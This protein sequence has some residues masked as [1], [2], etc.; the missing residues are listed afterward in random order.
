MVSPADPEPT[1]SLASPNNI[2]TVSFAE[3]SIRKQVYGRYSLLSSEGCRNLEVTDVIRSALT[4]TLRLSA[5]EQSMSHRPNRSVWRNGGHCP[6]GI[7][8]IPAN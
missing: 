7:C 6:S 1:S 3:Y 4:L 2:S 8:T 5:K